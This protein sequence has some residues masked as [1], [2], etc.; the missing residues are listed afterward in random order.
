MQA[1]HNRTAR[2]LE[3]FRDLR[4]GEALKLPQNQDLPIACLELA[5]SLLDLAARLGSFDIRQ[6][7]GPVI[8]PLDII[9]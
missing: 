5:N 3:Y 2:D 8:R 1:A 4:V 9:P 7:V 6:G